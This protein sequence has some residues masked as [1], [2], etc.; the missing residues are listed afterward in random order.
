MKKTDNSHLD[1]KINLRLETLNK[2]NKKSINVLEVY[3]GSGA[4]WSGVLKKTDK[5]INILKIEINSYS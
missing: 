3:A 2:I 1:K 5:N 4:I